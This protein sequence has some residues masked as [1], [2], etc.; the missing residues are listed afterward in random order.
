MPDATKAV[1]SSLPN[2]HSERDNRICDC[3]DPTKRSPKSAKTAIKIEVV[4]IRTPNFRTIGLTLWLENNVP[5]E[6]MNTVNTYFVDLD[7]RVLS[8]PVE[9]GIIQRKFAEANKTERYS[10]FQLLHRYIANVLFIFFLNFLISS[11][12]H[13]VES[14]NVEPRFRKSFR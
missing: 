4:T 6:Q 7:A 2:M 12:H 14:R 3:I 13:S 1:C 10:T 11:A 5:V 9:M 8:N